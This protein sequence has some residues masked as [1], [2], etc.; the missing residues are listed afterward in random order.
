MVYDHFPYI[1]L[2]PNGHCYSR[3]TLAPISLFTPDL[4]SNG[5][6][7]KRTEIAVN[8]H[9][10]QKNV[11]M[12]ATSPVEYPLQIIINC[13]SLPVVKHSLLENTPTSVRW[14]SQLE[15]ETFVRDFPAMLERPERNISIKNPNHPPK[16]S[17][18][19]HA[20]NWSSWL[21]L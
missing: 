15:T 14:C 20:S 4:K 17:S 5:F 13:G 1:S 16:W 18:Q 3:K 2:C 10:C 19:K 12:F 21:P 9:I 11:S 6:F 7:P 8:Y